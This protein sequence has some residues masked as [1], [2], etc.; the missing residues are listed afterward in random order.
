M[1]TASTTDEAYID[2][3]AHPLGIAFDPAWAS[4]RDRLHER[5]CAA[6]LNAAAE[7]EAAVRVPFLSTRLGEALA[8]VVMIGGMVGT[9][10]FLAIKLVF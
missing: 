8:G 3:P 9:A 7:R 2:V 1:S 4:V 10:W 5:Q 6:I